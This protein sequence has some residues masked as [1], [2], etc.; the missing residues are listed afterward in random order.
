VIGGGLA[1]MTSALAIAD[2][3]Y[4]VFLVEK[5]DQLGGNLRKLSQTAEGPN[6]QRLMRQ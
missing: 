3:G 2:E 5:T 1:G 6:P 4:D